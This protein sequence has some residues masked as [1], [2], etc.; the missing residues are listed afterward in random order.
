MVQEP[1]EVPPQP[2][3]P[4][5]EDPMQVNTTPRR[6]R[7]P[8]D[9]GDT[10]T[11]RPRVDMSAQISELCECDVPET[12]WEKLGENSSSVFNNTLGLKLDAALVK[13][14]RE[15][16]VKRLLEFEECEEVSEDLARETLRDGHWKVRIGVPCFAYNEKEDSMVLFH[17]DDFLAE[18][19]DSSLDKLDEVLGA[20]EIKRLPRIGPTA[21]REGVFLHKRRR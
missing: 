21:G 18:G 12:D 5:H 3:S 7:I 6:A 17:G 14:G 4:S 11:A 15:T 1:V 20:F 9:E 19:H 10:R 13:A 8:E 2:S 16:E